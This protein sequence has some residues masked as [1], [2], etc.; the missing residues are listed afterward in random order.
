LALLIGY[1]PTDRTDS[2]LALWNSRRAP[3][4]KADRMPVGRQ[5]EV[6]V[7]ILV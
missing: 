6:G 5:M 3:M 7:K 4:G 2:V 1:D